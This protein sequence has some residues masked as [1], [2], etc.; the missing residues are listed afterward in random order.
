MAFD[1][2]QFKELG[3]TYGGAR[4]TLFQVVVTPPAAL[5]FENSFSA[6]FAFTCRAAELP[7]SDVASFD[8]PYFGRKIKLAGDRTFAD[9]RVT[10]M[11]DEDF[12]VRAMFEKWSNWINTMETNNRLFGPQDY[13]SVLT[14]NQYSKGYN[15][16]QINDQAP[17]RSYSILGAFPTVVDAI[18]LDWNSTNAIEE[19][20]VTFAYDYWVPSMETSSVVYGAEI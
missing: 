20:S 18:S 11:N 9:W 7:A 16:G 12:L 8:V 5:G 1:I 14:V 17:I 4:P 19:F 6:K 13:K 2:N 15:P 10:I 3:L